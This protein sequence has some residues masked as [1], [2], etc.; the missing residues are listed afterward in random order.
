[1][2]LGVVEFSY[3]GFLPKNQH[4]YGKFLSFG[5]MASC[6]KVPKFDLQS[7]FS[8]S[9]IMGISLNFFFI[10]DYYKFWSTFFVI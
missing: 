7:Q 9:K 1:M 5:F 10:E 4:I 6:Q 3:G 8:T 2:A